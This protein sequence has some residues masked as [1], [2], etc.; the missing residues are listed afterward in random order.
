MTSRSLYGYTGLA[1]GV[2][3]LFQSILASVKYDYKISESWSITPFISL[4]QQRPW[5]ITDPIVA[6]TQVAAV[7]DISARR[8][9][10]GATSQFQVLKESHILVGGEVYR[11]EAS[12]KINQETLGVPTPFA[13]TNSDDIEFDGLAAYAQLETHFDWFDMTLGGRMEKIKTPTGREVSNTVPRFAITKATEGWHLKGLASQAF[14]TPSI[15]NFDENFKANG[16]ISTIRP[17][18]TTTFE[19]E[20]GVAISK[21][22]YFTANIFSTK[23]EDVIV[24]GYDGTNDTYTNYP[25][26]ATQGFELEYRKQLKSGFTTMNYSY[27]EVAEN[28]VTPYEVPGRKE[29]LGIPQHKFTFLKSMRTG[30]KKLQF[31]P[32]IVYLRTKQSLAYDPVADATYF[33]ELPSST[34][35]NLYFTY[36]DFYIKG[37][38]LGFGVF[39]LF[40]EENRFVQPYDPNTLT[41]D[42]TVVGATPGPSREFVARLTYSLYF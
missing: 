30:F 27:Y 21:R 11:D 22:S 38:E 6:T 12:M 40:D 36:P 8:T 20:G 14:R 24:Y 29:L 1:E 17:E 3:V 2:D 28:E 39:N 26:V 31:T 35:V 4:R 7:S 34:L 42:K 5:V 10:I 37:L 18:K 9:R 19:I 15:F 25:Q 32:S 23:I 33:K 13:M 16:N 41:A